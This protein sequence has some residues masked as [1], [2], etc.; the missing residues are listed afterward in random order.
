VLV[1]LDSYHQLMELL[2]DT[3]AVAVAE[4]QLVDRTTQT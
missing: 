3:L 2:H 1:E 4:A